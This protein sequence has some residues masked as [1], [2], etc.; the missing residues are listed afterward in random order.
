M[1]TKQV[2]LRQTFSRVITIAFKMLFLS[3][4]CVFM[5][6][7]FFLLFYATQI[8][9]REERAKLDD[10]QEYLIDLS[11]LLGDEWHSGGV[12]RSTDDARGW[13]SSIAGT[14]FHNASHTQNRLAGV[15]QSI[16]TYVDAEQARER[17][18]VQEDWI[19][20]RNL[21]V[22]PSTY[23]DI[24]LPS[25]TT[26]RADEYRI[27]CKDIYLDHALIEIRCVGLFLYENHIVRV[28]GYT[29][30]D[31]VR[32]LSMNDLAM[33]INAVDNRMVSGE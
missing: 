30:R 29:M 4:V 27:A 16:T 20:L 11:E 19:F 22:P 26:L 10:S 14:S 9:E 1:N 12:G 28:S 2:F 21:G 6:V 17:Y 23:E 7:L 15:G 24:S 18:F 13:H 32:Y 31:F 25:D 33:I 5:C 8:Q 3:C